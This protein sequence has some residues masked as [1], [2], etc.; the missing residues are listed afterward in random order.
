M[1]RSRK[2][3]TTALAAAALLGLPA[4]GWA[5]SPETSPAAQ[6]PTAQHSEH[7]TPQ[8][9]LSKAKAALDSVETASVPASAKNKVTELKRRVSALEKSAAEGAPASQKTTGKSTWST[10]V[11]EIDKILAE[12][13]GPAT[14]ATPES[15]TP[16]GTTGSRTGEDAKIDEA[17]KSKLMEVRTHVTAFAA[18]MSGTGA[19]PGA[20]EPAGDPAASAAAAASA[21]PAPTTSQPPASA[22]AASTPT[23]DPSST[24]PAT[25]SNAAQPP[26]SQAPTTTGAG[27]QPQQSSPAPDANEE[28]VKQHLTA[29][30]NSLSELTQLPA[31]AQLTGEARTQVSQLITNFNELIT[32]KTEWRASFEKVDANVTA[33][34]GPEAASADPA[35]AQ[36]QPPTGTTGAVGTTGATAANIDPAIKAKLVEFKAHLEKFEKAAGAGAS[37]ASPESAAAPASPAS[38]SPGAT[39]TPTEPSTAEPGAMDQESAMRHIEAIEAIVSGEAAASGITLDRTKVEQIRTHLA[40]LR[41][42]VQH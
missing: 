26:T 14:R 36:A 13:I 31:A 6:K 35:Q 42:A 38:S 32:T 7:G 29:A 27:Q 15:Q 5:Q 22:S 1:T 16:A 34:L 28:E 20:T 12:M 11:A 21:Q 37:S 2:R 39:P 23:P 41:K 3:W 19:T 18:A 17:T 30:R 40:E 9:H 4:A 24:A 25:G 8:E 10:H 33:L